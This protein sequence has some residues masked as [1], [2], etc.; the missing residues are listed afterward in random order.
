MHGSQPEGDGAP[1]L[2]QNATLPEAG[3]TLNHRL[4]PLH[5]PHALFRASARFET[6]RAVS[7]CGVRFVTLRQK[8]PCAWP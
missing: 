1:C 8:A 2:A 4:P 3:G 5:T 6:R 7:G